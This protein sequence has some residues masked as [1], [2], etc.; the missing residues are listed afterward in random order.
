[1]CEI[2]PCRIAYY[3]ELPGLICSN[4]IISEWRTELQ[5][6]VVIVEVSEED[7]AT[8]EEEVIVEGEEVEETEA[9]AEAEEEEERRRR[10][11]SP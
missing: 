3:I 10:I 5:P 7:L 11:G 4:F 2:V 6:A 9:V 8:E 1:M